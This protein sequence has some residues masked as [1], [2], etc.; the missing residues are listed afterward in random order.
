M[1]LCE[2]EALILRTYSLAEA[3]K[4]IVALTQDHGVIRGVAKGAKRLK[5]QFGGSLEPF[6]VV[7]I[8]YFQKENVELASIRHIEIVKSYF[9]IA[10][11]PEFL[12]KFAYLIELLIEFAPPHD[13]NERLYRMA[14]VCLETVSDIPESLESTSVYFQIWLLKLCGYLPDWGSCERCGNDFREDDSAALQLNFRLRCSKCRDSRVDKTVPPG[15]RS[16]WLTVQSKAPARFFEISGG[17]S[18]DFSEITIILRRIVSQILGR[19]VFGETI[20]S[21][22]G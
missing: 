20:L 12:Q 9:K 5:S 16:I 18:N 17:R 11:S 3:D 19:E 21:A 13:P 4:I 14:K 10:S 2:S 22:K 8:T 7:Q 15:I 6:S 1:G